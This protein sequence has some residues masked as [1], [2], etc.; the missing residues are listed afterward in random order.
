MAEGKK[1]WRSTE[2][3]GF[4]PGGHKGKLHSEMGIPSGEKIPAAKL[5]AA[6]NSSNP[7]K[8]RD[9]IRAET[10]KKWHHGSQKAHAGK[11]TIMKSLYGESDNG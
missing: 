3:E 10:M 5:H 8:K 6:A 7:E 2:K 11:K 1:K 4:H 9:A